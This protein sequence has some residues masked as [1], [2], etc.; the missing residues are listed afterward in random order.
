MKKLI[1]LITVITVILSFSL[2]A[3]AAEST[4]L[5]QAIESG[6]TADGLTDLGLAA[7]ESKDDKVLKS[8]VKSFKGKFTSLFAELNTLNPTDA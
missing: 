4:D 1:T 2:P 8:D 5:G 7:S 6:I 3:F